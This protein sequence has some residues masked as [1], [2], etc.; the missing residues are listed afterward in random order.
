MDTERGCTLG[1][2]TLGSQVVCIECGDDCECYVCVPYD[3]ESEE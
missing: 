2:S 3:E 1:P